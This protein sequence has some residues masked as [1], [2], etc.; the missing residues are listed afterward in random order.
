MLTS[1]QTKENVMPSCIK[2]LTSSKVSLCVAQITD[3]PVKRSN[4][5]NK[6]FSPCGPFGIEPV[7][8]IKNVSNSLVKENTNVVLYFETYVATW[9]PWQ[10]WTYL[11][12]SVIIPGHQYHFMMN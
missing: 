6:C 7:K 12:M 11:C 5:R 1:G 9:Q 10:L 4:A 2:F 8:S 3:Q